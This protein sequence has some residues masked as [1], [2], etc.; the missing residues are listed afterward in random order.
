MTGLICRAPQVRSNHLQLCLQVGKERG[1]LKMY[2][3]HSFKGEGIM[4]SKEM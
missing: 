4:K 1:L 2:I 3:F